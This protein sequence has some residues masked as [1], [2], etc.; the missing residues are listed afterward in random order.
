MKF[1]S[2]EHW[3]TFKTGLVPPKP[4][5][6]DS[7]NATNPALQLWI[8]ARDRGDTETTCKSWLQLTSGTF[9]SIRVKFYA[10]WSPSYDQS[11]SRGEPTPITISC[12]KWETL[13]LMSK[14]GLE[15]LNERPITTRN[16]SL[17]RACARRGVEEL[18]SWENIDSWP[19]EDNLPLELQ[20]QFF[21]SLLAIASCARR[22]LVASEPGSV[23]AALDE[24]RELEDWE[25]LH[26]ALSAAALS[27]A[28]AADLGA[29]EAMVAHYALRN[30]A[31]HVGGVVE[32][33]TE[34]RKLRWQQA[35][36]WQQRI[37]QR[38]MDDAGTRKWW[39]YN[40]HGLGDAQRKLSLYR[41][42]ALTSEALPPTS[43]I[44]SGA[45]DDDETIE[46]L[47]TC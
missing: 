23:L 20:P 5:T 25:Q 36:Y 17:A 6:F 2:D 43:F 18:A 4:K 19:D 9:P 34:A 45:T 3:A 15:K 14:L 32:G 12:L 47:L 46:S 38:L 31:G 22:I 13:C 26:P 28:R 33:G 11:E 40:I 21:K 7:T 8:R 16:T 42:L 44:E 10:T 29:S 1:V 27:L 35:L 24:S 30:G 39:F 41:R 37:V